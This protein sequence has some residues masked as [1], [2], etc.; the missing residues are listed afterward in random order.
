MSLYFDQLMS[1]WKFDVIVNCTGIGARELTS[2]NDVTPIRGQVS[3]V[4]TSLFLVFYVACA[5]GI[6]LPAPFF[7]F[8]VKAPWIKHFMTYQ[9]SDEHCEKYIF[10]GYKYDLKLVF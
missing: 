10:P 5:I 7:L 6:L 3:R 1:K 4:I 8:Q 9:E 2:D